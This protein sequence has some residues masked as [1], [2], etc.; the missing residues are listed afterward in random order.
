MR[1]LGRNTKWIGGLLSLALA[2]SLLW[3]IFYHQ[4]AETTN[5]K[6]KESVQVSPMPPQSGAKTN[7]LNPSE[8]TRLAESY[9]RLSLSF[10]ANAGQTD[11]QVKF[12]ARGQGY[13][14]FLTPTEAVLALSK[15]KAE[16]S[17]HQ[18][19]GGL[20]RA[21][22]DARKLPEQETAILRM[23]LR[24]ANSAPEMVGDMPLAA[25]TNYF[26]GN[27][28]KQWRTGVASFSKVRYQQVYPGIDLVYYGNQRQLEYDFI[29]EPGADPRVI[30][31][32]FEGADEVRVDS[33]GELVLE[34]LTGEVRQHKPIIYQ[35]A[36]GVRKTIVGNYQ[37]K[38]LNLVGFVVEDY[39]PAQTLVIDPTL[40][41]STYLGGTN[42][43]AAGAP[44]AIAVDDFGNAYVTG[45]TS[46]TDFPTSN[47]Y[48]TG[49]TSDDVF[50]TKLNTLASGAASLLYST[51]LGGNSGDY[52]W[53]IAV[54]G[55]GNAYVTGSTL[56]TNFPTSNAYQPD[57]PGED[58]FVTKLNT[59]ASGAAS[60]LYSTYL[61]G[62]LTEEGNGIAVDGSGNAYVMGHTDSTDFPTSNA[63]QTDQVGIDAFV[64]KLNTLASGAAS[65]LYSTYLGGNSH[66]YGWGIAVDGS[67]NAYVTGSTDS[68][69]F[70]TSNAYQT[71][72]PGWDVFVTKLNTLGSG[73]ASLLYSTYLG[74]N[75][76]D[77]GYGIVADSSGNAYVTGYT[78]SPNFPTSNAYQTDQPYEDAFVTKLNTLGSGAASLLYSTYLGGNS[79]DAGQGISL[80]SSGNAYVTGNTSSTD[81][82]NSNA[83]QTDQP[84]IDVFVTKISFSGT[85]LV[86]RSPAS[87]T[88]GD[89]MVGTT[90]AA[91]TITLVNSGDAVMNLS[92]IVTSGDF[93]PNNQCGANVSPGANCTIDVTFI[94]TLS[95]ARTGILSISSD[96]FGSP[97]TVNLSGTGVAPPVPTATLSP[98]SLTFGVQP[99][100]PAGMV[101]DLIITN[102]GTGTLN[103]TSL[104][105]AGANPGDF[106][107]SSSTLPLSLSPGNSTSISLHFAPTAAGSRSASFTVTSNA[108]DSPQSVSL[109]GDGA[110]ASL[111]AW[112]ENGNGQLGNG[113]A[114]L[115]RTPVQVSGLNQVLA[116]AGRTTHTLAFKADGTVWAWGKSGNGELGNGTL[117]TSTV[118]V[119]VSSITNASRVAA[120]HNHSLAAKSDGSLWGWGSNG[121]GQL[122]LGNLQFS[123]TPL[124]ISSLSQVTAIAAGDTHSLVVKSDGTLWSFGQN[125]SGQLGDGTTTFSKVPVQVTSLTGVL[126][127]A[128]GSS[129]SLAL[130]SDGTVWAWGLNTSGQLGNGTTSSSTLPVQVSGLTG[131]LTI[132][133]GAFHS[134]ALKSDG[135]VWAWGNNGNGKLGDGTLTNRTT[136]VQVS[137]LTSA[138]AIA[139]GGS[140]SLA[141]QSDGS[142][143]AWGRN[144][145][146]QLGNNGNANSSIPLQIPGLTGAT[147]IAAGVDHNL[148]VSISPI[149]SPSLGSQSLTFASQ[150]LGTTSTAQSLTIINTGPG[151][152]VLGDAQLSGS[153]LNDFSIET[154]TCW[155]AEVFPGQNC[156]MSVT[157]TPSATGSRTA[158]LILYNNAFDSPHTI[159]VTGTAILPTA[160]VS[161]TS[162]TFVDRPVGSTSPGQAVTLS[163]TSTA[164]L[165][166]ASIATSGDF[167]R[168]SNCPI[169]PAT[170]AAGAN[171]TIDV[172]FTPAVTGARTGALTITSNASN[173][174]HTVNLAGNGIVVIPSA[175]RQVLIDLYNS[176]NGANWTNKTNWLG[177]PGT[178]C[179][180]FGVVCNA[181]QTAVIQVSL[182]SNSLNGSIPPSLGTLGSLQ[183]LSLSG[184]QLSGSIPAN[185]GGLSNLTI[186]NLSLNQLSGNIPAA[187][188][189]LAQLRSLLLSN[190][191]LG[192]IIP[193]QLSNLAQLQILWL[194]SN[195]LSGTIPVGIGN[196][197]NLTRLDL[198][199]NQLTGTIPS[200]L[201][202]LTSLQIL[203]LRQNQLSGNIPTSVGNLSSLTL[204]NL[205]TNQLTGTI[206]SQIGGLAQLQ[207]LFLSGNHL[208]GA[209]PTS[210]GNL[211]HLKRLGFTNNQ[212]TGNIPSQIGNL[213]SLE[214]L[215]LNSNQLS[216]NVP[217]SLSNLTALS[218]LELRWNA[219]Y[220]NDT[221]LAALLDSKQTG[222][223]WQST[224][225]IAPTSLSTNV[226]SSSSILL[227]WTPIAYTSDPGR[228][229]ALKSTLSAGPY[230]SAG[231][232][233]K[234]SSGLTITG[235]DPGTTYYFVIQTETNPHPNN[236]NFVTSGI[237]AEISATTQAPPAPV[238]SLSTTSLGF[239]TQTTGTGS[240]PQT[241]T[242][243]NTGNLPLSLTQITTV[244]GFPFGGTCS[245]SSSVQAGQSCTI[246]VQFFPSVGGSY[247]GNIQV[248]SNG[249]GSPHAIALSG[250]AFAV[251]STGL[252]SSANP[253]VQGT[254]IS[255][256]TT[257]S[258]NLGVPNGT[259][260]L[261]DFASLVTTL[262]L[263]GGTATHAFTP[264][265]GSHSY[266]AVYQPTGFFATSTSAVL[267]QVVTAPTPIGTNVSPSSTVETSTITPTFLSVTSP[268]Q[269]TV[270]P[271]AA[272]SAGTVPGGY[273]ISGSTLA[274]EIS[275]TASLGGIDPNNPATWIVIRFDVPSITNSLAFANL[276]VLHNESGVLVDRTILS[277]PSAPDFPNKRIYARVP[278]LSPFVLSQVTGTTIPQVTGP[279]NPLALGATATVVA[280]FTDV[281]SQTSHTCTF[282]WEDG[283]P[284]TT[285]TAASG[286]SGSCSASHVYSQAGVYTVTVTVSNG[287]G[288]PANSKFEYVV[289][290]DPSGGFVTGGGWITSPA[291]AYVAAPSLTGKAT[292][293]FVSKYNKGT[294]V[295]SGQTE[296][297]FHVASF[298]FQSTVYQW[299][300]IAGARAQYK[301]SGTINGGG[302][303]GFLLT[304]IDGQVNGGGGV[305]KFR[306]KIWDK[307]NNDAI[308]YDNQI[309]STDTADLT[310]PGT[311]L[312]GGSIVIHK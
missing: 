310:T 229:A 39:D 269:T 204:L 70:P 59:L 85:P 63:Y 253:V 68:T 78:D 149:L 95:G 248:S 166:I 83:Y 294:T 267:Q 38:S 207:S 238:V 302:N 297:Q 130:K 218:G 86:S 188:G 99:V 26:I 262:P 6:V 7:E 189:D 290:F 245:V 161:P 285:V 94:P 141:L 185:L 217:A 257:V 201:G 115:S 41:Y 215:Y 279:L 301:G 8:K 264:A 13:N 178:E 206:P 42:S 283:T 232:T 45:Y 132:T 280:Q 180:W 66:E 69:N 9:G 160:S 97:H 274:F 143:W 92:S 224:Q 56:S 195:Q 52:G 21:V 241:I 209:I 20:K 142:G 140:H 43:D 120:G 65:L 74:G 249:P 270:A 110:T 196:L 18:A 284:N 219:L 89:Q 117:T 47:E 31:M 237:S 298:N 184:N 77:L 64:T 281:A 12:L 103:I 126:E 114:A 14:L 101:Q 247:S 113:T 1:H 152:F 84:D 163:N 158:T 272:S 36:R 277:G 168:T 311:L 124:Q 96:A 271:I 170:L 147:L 282:S 300:V 55:S 93:S 145:F 40:S 25:K 223:D 190:N 24:G 292:F 303:Y 100:G 151:P 228:Y 306:I 235:L 150:F 200:E 194:E 174:P 88:F 123:T 213:A 265:V 98:S 76:G 266:T 198:S 87:L 246:V 91:Q 258:S 19:S 5:P 131:V 153:N 308:V 44:G 102:S 181:S 220:S 221:G 199:N 293:G 90:S 242:V 50:V 260:Q 61:G 104:A 172:T 49:T 32:T 111:L 127:V 202:S 171:C 234:T 167:A 51:Y 58:A 35:E 183:S 4:S 10:E 155:G 182:G 254:S 118:P 231:F 53:G 73:A 33:N 263:S 164:A 80:D 162:L 214:I 72:Q 134:L 186:L 119:Q 133:A 304:A 240:A 193:S 210:L 29:V 236:Q 278:S 54:D 165:T 34:T 312:G 159:S 71:D 276:R 79:I 75:S 3:Q 212:L 239:G 28:P 191:P 16:S 256:T 57:Q 286:A 216:G 275:T 157:F 197:L 187:L 251:T 176:T 222:G 179:T 225:T 30:Q 148:A 226:Q 203:E 173:S 11:E 112:G 2:V 139:A 121:I 129:H 105:L 144:T 208:S 291:G 125:G 261:F 128:G 250:T 154:N 295:P 243:T 27:D 255:L 169:N 205:S 273:S 211:S 122:G 109:S 299:L 17:N 230:S 289:V 268:G 175:E 107:A 244:A 288:A 15:P 192:G 46:S 227:S 305:D 108:A 146:G 136:P 259:V 177:V 252:T 135:T 81:F 60:L 82:P 138:V 23:K 22:G 137:G 296:F 309:S 62:N 116:L 67:G 48:Q 37:I 307:N 106:R 233:P 156:I 287:T